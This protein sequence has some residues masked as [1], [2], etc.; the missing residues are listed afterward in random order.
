M[1]CIS[2]PGNHNLKVMLY[3][4]FTINVPE[5]ERK[6]KESDIDRDFKSFNLNFTILEFLN[7]VYWDNGLRNR[8]V[9]R[10]IQ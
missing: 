9:I 6:H 3:Y 8:V 7:V 4:Y 10:A 1:E 2:R 5:T